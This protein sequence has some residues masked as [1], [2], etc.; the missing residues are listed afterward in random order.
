M[1]E[2]QIDVCSD[3]RSE[4]P[5]LGVHMNQTLTSQSSESESTNVSRSSTPDFKTEPSNEEKL[6]KHSTPLNRHIT[7][8]NMYNINQMYQ[9]HGQFYSSPN[10]FQYNRPVVKSQENRPEFN[11]AQNYQVKNSQNG[12][13]INFCCVCGDRASGKHYGV[14]SCD[15]CRGFFKRS[16]RGNMEYVCKEN[17]NCFIDVSRRNQCQ[18]CRLRK[19][20][21]VKMNRDAVQHQ[22]PPRSQQIKRDSTSLAS[23]LTTGQTSKQYIQQYQPSFYSPRFSPY[24]VPVKNIRADIQPGFS[25][26]NYPNFSPAVAAAVAFQSNLANN[27]LAASIKNQI[28][29]KQMYQMENVSSINTS[30]PFIN[31]S[32]NSSGY[33]TY[34]EGRNE[35]SSPEVEQ[36]DED[37]FEKSKIH[38]SA[39]LAHIMNWIKSTPTTENLID[40]TTKILYSA[41]R[42]ARTQKSF[43]N[44]SLQSQSTLINENLNELFILQMAE[45]KSIMNELNILIENEK[46][47]EKK[48]LIQG[49]FNLLQKFNLDKVDPMEFY[50]LKSIALFKSEINLE[51]KQKIEHTQEE[52]FMS[53][54]NY[55]KLNYPNMPRFGK[56]L[57]LYSDI[58]K[59]TNTKIVEEVFLRN[60]QSKINLSNLLLAQTT[61]A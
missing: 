44:L 58:R 12:K 9:N 2:N 51:D 29:L 46:N 42:W 3:E 32:E 59:Y 23:P 20:L 6:V 17:N 28:A 41:I 39:S 31:T 36:K 15:G 27:L 61:S 57:I 16:I 56:L 4:S 34:D 33:Q 19:C 54:Y 53:L 5:V 25:Q 40:S 22:R 60:I 24:N 1:Y 48:A 47:D 7:N 38:S 26:D 30:I 37:N 11:V 10:M 43:V 45:T 14:L 35:T 8:E 55:N 52:S 13:P 18:A 50:L 21:E 49:F